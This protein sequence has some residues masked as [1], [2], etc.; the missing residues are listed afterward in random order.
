MDQVLEQVRTRD[1]IGRTEP[2]SAVMAQTDEAMLDV[3][4]RASALAMQKQYWWQRCTEISDALRV[5]EDE[6]ARLRVALA[7]SQSSPA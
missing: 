4:R 3:R 1:W 5:A 6:V 7:L 2:V